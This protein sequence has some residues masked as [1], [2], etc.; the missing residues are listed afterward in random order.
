VNIRNAI[1]VLVLLLRMRNP[2][3]EYVMTEQ[4]SAPPSQFYDL[5]K[6]LLSAVVMIFLALWTLF[7]G[8]WVFD[9]FWCICGLLIHWEWQRMVDQSALMK[10]LIIGS[11][12]ILLIAFLAQS[13]NAE[14]AFMVLVLGVAAVG[15]SAPKGQGLWHSAGVLYAGAMVLAIYVLRHSV[16][17]GIEAIIWLFALVWGTDVMAYVGGRIIGGPKLWPRISPS[18][19]WSG[20][21]TGVCSGACLGVVVLSLM[22][23]STLSMTNVFVLGLLTCALAQAG[24]LF[25]SS[26]KRHFHIK[27][28]SHLIPGHGG[29]MDRLDGFIFAVVFAACVGSV[30]AGVAAASHGL[31]AW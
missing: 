2:V 17:D 9:L 19:T 3:V 13:H 7:R 24:D 12:I 18:K 20:F 1:V 15:F 22:S 30:L 23:S 10:R 8:G 27:D 28:A 29:F 4:A 25:E 21:I 5:P 26:I 14:L 6:R 31:V 11:I 16:L